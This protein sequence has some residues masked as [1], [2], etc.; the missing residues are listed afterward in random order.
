MG[1]KS[2]IQG[3]LW[4]YSRS[5]SLLTMPTDA[6][7]VFDWLSSWPFGILSSPLGACCSKYVGTAASWR[8]RVGHAW[9]MRTSR[10]GVT[11]TPFQL[12]NA[13][14]C[15]HSSS[16]TKIALYFYPTYSPKCLGIWRWGSYRVPRI[17][18]TKHQH[19]HPGREPSGLRG[20][21]LPHSR[22]YNAGA[23]HVGRP[24]SRIPRN[25]SCVAHK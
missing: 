13:P 16:H 20:G 18:Q 10:D 2:S 25:A 5:C 1:R 12:P 8:A 7:V 19:T 21:A 24:E 4:T 3:D 17:L 22:F 15:V 14:S 23:Q 9:R 11:T 6:R